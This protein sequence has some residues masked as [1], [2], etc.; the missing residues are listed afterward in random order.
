VQRGWSLGGAGSIK[1]DVKR[2]HFPDLLKALDREINE[3][4]EFVNN[5]PAIGLLPALAAAVE[6]GDAEPLEQQ[7]SS[8]EELIEQGLA[9]LWQPNTNPSA[10]ATSILTNV[11]AQNAEANLIANGYN[12]ISQLNGPNGPVTVLSNGVTTFTIYIANS[13]G[14]WSG[15]VNSGGQI[16]TK[17]RFGN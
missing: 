1:G 7:V 5:N 16:L 14:A 2:K 13:T 3:L 10:L 6:G 11:S 8:L 4:S 15:Q 12:V 17:I 9:S